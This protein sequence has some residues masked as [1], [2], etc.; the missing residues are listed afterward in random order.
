M[1]WFLDTNDDDDVVST[2]H[3]Q[4]LEAVI[5][6]DEFTGAEWTSTMIAIGIL[7]TYFYQPMSTRLTH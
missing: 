6:Q 1:L 7:N 2:C 3:N 4:Q 5:K